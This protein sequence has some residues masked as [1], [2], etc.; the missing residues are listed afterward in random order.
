MTRGRLVAACLALAA[1][2]GIAAGAAE[3]AGTARLSVTPSAA[4]VGDRLDAVL[5]VTVPE[6]VTVERPD[7]GLEL[8]PFSVFEPTWEGPVA[9][10]GESRFTLRARLAAFETGTLEVPSIE[11]RVTGPG[12]PAV[13]KSEPVKVEVRSVLTGK[14]AAAPGKPDL[15]D[16]KPP[17]TIPPDYRPLWIALLVL[18][19][20]GAAAGLAWWLHRRY[21]ARLA[22]V[23]AP[24][25]PFRRLPPHVWAYAELKRLLD[26]KLADEGE[27]ELFFAELSRILK[28]YLGGRYRVP[29]MEHTTGEVSALLAESGAPQDAVRSARSL[30]ELC[31]GVKFARELP[32]PAWCRASVDEAYRIVD[33]TRPAEE[34]AAAGGPATEEKGAA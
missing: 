15:A 11:V 20:L 18:A 8:G 33:A 12:G 16:L 14:D 3:I 31:D 4:T 23:A 30:L 21:A 19:G 10:A 34:P 2:L 1:A 6:G 9:A 17:A 27:I 32:E 5:E 13:L 7:L 29:L 25:D 26:R 24:E 28:L 22:A